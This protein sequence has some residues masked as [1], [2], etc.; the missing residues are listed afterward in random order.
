M[1]VAGTMKQLQLVDF[2]APLHCLV[3]TGHTHPVE[4]EMLDFY[5]L[6]TQNLKQEDNG[7]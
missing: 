3:I 7:V 6:E 1:I 2:G 5:R 4:E